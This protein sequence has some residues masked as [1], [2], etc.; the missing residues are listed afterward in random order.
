[1]IRNFISKLSG[2][3]APEVKAPLP[4]PA[5]D[6]RIY[7]IGDIHGRVDLAKKLTEKILRDAE[8]FSDGRRLRLIYLG[9]YVDR[10]DHSQEAVEYLISL[11]ADSAGPPAEFL[12]GN[13]EAA[14]LSFLDDPVANRD[15]LGFGGCQTCASYLK[16]VPDLRC[17]DAELLKLAEDLGE[18]AAP[19]LDFLAETKI[20][21]HSGDV[22]FAHAAWEPARPVDDQPEAVALWGA[23]PAEEPGETKLL[24]HGHYDAP[25]P[26]ETPTRICV[27]TGAY[28]TGRLAAV[29]LD[30]R[31]DFIFSS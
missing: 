23:S 8:Q 15:W 29:R 20:A 13:H 26:V 2:K 14:M 6:E 17:S 1:M 10:G 18:A 12:R 27:D 30:E 25:N 9:D 21:L 5:R 7:A 31:R 16:K 19:H 4:G 22:I 11:K 28:Y 24:V 3:R